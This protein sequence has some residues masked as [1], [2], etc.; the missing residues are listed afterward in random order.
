MEQCPYT[1]EQ[2]KA[3]TSRT[4]SNAEKEAGTWNSALTL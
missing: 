3:M 2:L 1:L 4:D